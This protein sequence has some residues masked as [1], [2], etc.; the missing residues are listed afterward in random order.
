MTLDIH[1][2][3]ASHQETDQVKILFG[4]TPGVL[5]QIRDND[6]DYLDSQLLLQDVAYYPI[7]HPYPTEGLNFSPT[8][9]SGVAGILASLMGQ[10]SEGED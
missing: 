1:G 9:M 6:L 10:A 5:L 3:K 4:E 2:L 7:G 8:A